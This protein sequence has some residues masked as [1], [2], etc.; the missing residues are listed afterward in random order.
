MQNPHLTQAVMSWGAPVATAPGAVIALHGREQ[1]PAFIHGVCN[2]IGLAGLAWLAPAAAEKSWYPR[3]FTASLADN[4]PGLTHSLERIESLVRELLAAG[5][6]RQR[7]A[8]LGFSQ[9]AC[10]VAEYALRHPHRYGALV[11]LT[12]SSI[13]PAGTTWPPAGDLA[14]TPVLVSGSTRDAWVPLARMRQTAVLL[15][16]RG[17]RVREYY[18]SGDEHIVNEDEIGMAR[19]MLAALLDRRS[20]REAV[21]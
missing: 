11:I 1:P 13:G 10:M 16:D 5:H 15:K 3:A 7:I 20:A 12:G 4:E 17:A 2:R 14:G 21:A 18:Y 9:G 8:L 6:E 19:Q